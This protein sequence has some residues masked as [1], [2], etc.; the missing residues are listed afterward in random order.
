MNSLRTAGQLN[1]GEYLITTSAEFG[2]SVP[3]HRLKLREA[4][5]ERVR[6]QITATTGNAASPADLAP[7][8]FLNLTDLSKPPR[9]SGWAISVSHCPSLGGFVAAPSN[10]HVGLDFELASRVSSQIA[11]RVAAF[12]GE[13]KILEKVTSADRPLALF[14]AAKEAAI[15]AFGNRDPLLSP[16]FGIVEILDIDL[17]QSSFTAAHLESRARGHIFNVTS[18]ILGA[19]AETASLSKS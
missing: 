15:K 14:W 5:R 6:D 7:S 8:D 4:L 13:E 19:L 2:S 10:S 9:L 12:A 16:H 3:D 1:V 18:E 17:E 11:R